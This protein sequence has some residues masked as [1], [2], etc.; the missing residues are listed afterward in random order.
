MR[1]FIAAAM[2]ALEISSARARAAPV[3]IAL[4]CTLLLLVLNVCAAQAQSVGGRNLSPMQFDM[5]CAMT[6]GEELGVSQNEQDFP[7][8]D[9]ALTIFVFYLGRL[10]GRDDNVDWNT[11]ARGRAA[12]LRD[13][14]RSPELFDACMYFYFS[15]IK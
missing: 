2:L 5:A 11:V 15:K 12:E 7:R 8:R 10:S 13:K 4:C 9:M 1:N 3:V 14:A 6:T